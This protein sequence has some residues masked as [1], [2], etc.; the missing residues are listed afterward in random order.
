MRGQ[1]I[2]KYVG[3]IITNATANARRAEAQSA[4]RK[5]VYLF[6]LDKFN[7]KASHDPRLAC[8]PYEIDG[9]NASGPTRFIN[10]SCDPNLRI[11]ARVADYC[12]KDLHELAFFA[13]DDI[14]AGTELTFDYVD[15]KPGDL[16]SVDKED[17]TVCLC[18]AGNCRG[19]LW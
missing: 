5:D 6:A 7:D 15:G 8:E 11:V 14:E 4:K 13:L 12:E 19:F 2:D 1:Y 16:D 9:E 10:H 3:E 18:G 17:M